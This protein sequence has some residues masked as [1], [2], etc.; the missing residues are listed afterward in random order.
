MEIITRQDL[1]SALDAGRELTLVEALQPAAFEEAHLPGAVNIPK[2]RVRELAPRL[3]PDK[4]A[5][6]VVYCANTECQSSRQV[7]EA[8]E[9]LG[10]THVADYEDG[11]QD[12]LD[13]GLPVET[14]VTAAAG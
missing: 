9:G 7:A 10:Y 1:K 3:L 6:I 11:K 2:D 5:E 14:G 13:A 8:L 4:D 12:W